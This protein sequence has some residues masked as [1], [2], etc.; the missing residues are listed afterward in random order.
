MRTSKSQLLRE[1]ALTLK[2]CVF[3]G[4]PGSQTINWRNNWALKE[5]YVHKYEEPNQI[6]SF[7]AL[8]REYPTFA[9][10]YLLVEECGR[11]VSATVSPSKLS[12]YDN[13][14]LNLT[15]CSSFPCL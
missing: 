14:H 10:A 3:I 13:H 15:N 2:H 1:S 4:C 7:Y 12:M 9:D 8:F 5:A 11:G 6:I